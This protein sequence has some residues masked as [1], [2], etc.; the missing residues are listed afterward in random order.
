MRDPGCYILRSFFVCRNAPLGG[1]A[2]TGVVS[3]RRIAQLV[4]R[5]PYKAEARRSIRLPPIFQ[6][7]AISS[8]LTARREPRGCIPIG[9][10]LLAM[11]LYGRD[12]CGAVVQLVRTP[13]CHAGG[14]GFEPRRPRHSP[15]SGLRNVGPDFPGRGCERFLTFSSFSTPQSGLRNAGPDFPGRGCERSLR[16]LRNLGPFLPNQSMV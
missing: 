4:E 12:E 15:Q 13:A 5:C 16:G 14:H 11:S 2:A 7:T 10:E 8:E 3:I 1:H 9:Y 6:E